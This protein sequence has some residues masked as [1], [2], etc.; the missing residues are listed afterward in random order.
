MI[1]SSSRQAAVGLDAAQY[2]ILAYPLG[3]DVV[4]TDA[5]LKS[6]SDSCRFQQ[7]ADGD[8]HVP[9]SRDL[10][11]CLHRVLGVDFL[12]GARAVI[13]NPHFSHFHSPEE[14]DIALG[15]VK[16]WPL[17]PA[18]LLLDSFAPAD[19]AQALT[20]A[21]NHGREVYILRHDRPSPAAME[22]LKT[23]RSMR[24][25]LLAI[26]PPKSLV[27]HSIQCW[28]T[29]QWDSVPSLYSSQIWLLRSPARPMLSPD[30]CKLQSL[31]G[32]WNKRR[33]DFHH[34]PEPIPQQL[35]LYRIGQQDA[36]LY[37]G[38]GFFAG[39]D[40]SVQRK[41]ERMGTGYVVTHGTDL[42]PIQIFCA[43]VGGPLASIR[44][45]ATGLLYLLRW[46]RAT[47]RGT[48]RLVIFIDC[49]GLLQILSKWG[50]KEFWPGP[51]DVIHFDVL[52][53]LLQ[54][55]REWTSELVLMK[56]KSHAGCYHND[57]SD[58]Q[59]DLGCT[60]ENESLC[61]GPQK[62]GTLHLRI[63][64]SLHSL[65]EREKACVVLPQD[66]APNKVILRKVV[67]FNTQRAVKIR[68]TIFVRDFV[69]RTEGY[70]IARL[71]SDCSDSEIRCWMRFMTA[72]YP[73]ATYLHRIGKTQSN[74][75]QHCS[76]G[77][78]ETLSHF[79]SI[80]PRFHDA[81]TAAHN[82]IRERLSTLLRK[83]LSAAWTL[84]EE[85]PMAVTGLRLLPVATASVQATGRPVS[86][87]DI[88]KG[89]MALGRWRPDFLVV[90][91]A[92]RKVAILELC[93]PSD[94]STD[95]LQNAYNRKLEIYGP[96]RE[97][98]K[99]YLDSGWAVQILPW[100]VG[101]RGLIQECN[102][103]KALEFLEVPKGNWRSITD[104]TVSA[105]I[106][107]LAFMHRVRF[108]TQQVV[109]T[110]AT[111]SKCQPAEDSSNRR[112]KRKAAPDDHSALMA[113]WKCM[114]TSTRRS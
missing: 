2:G 18:L 51:K 22:D 69:Q 103:Y 31:L 114:T 87:A 92:R 29:A 26:I 42:A 30:A 8:Y 95:M 107:A 102:L 35:S 94:V 53:P 100:V 85:T 112:G 28:Q 41:Q 98:L 66:T 91:F 96:L 86:T 48:E 4:P 93:R 79:L 64:P 109:S 14:V 5:L 55:L 88:E 1:L 16:H 108:S 40:G 52:L 99:Y 61:P 76:L 46:F 82:Q 70:A 32:S 49:L 77:Q 44:A 47:W 68:T 90:S 75:C 111:M 24:A 12:L 25:C 65:A 81:R 60:S 6:I 72:T 20:T 73:V 67:S 23:I 83:R 104:G 71:I 63:K 34:H 39:S 58:E 105:S 37:S 56:V 106:S 89:T 38:E 62:Y 13:S 78:K 113:R 19:R 27:L 74:I 43:P 50:T 17:L 57:L 7:Q 11:A 80:C 59:A 36:I 10:L 110:S 33:Y 84:F 97:A 21:S 9:W 3:R 101:A 45:E 54:L 15:A